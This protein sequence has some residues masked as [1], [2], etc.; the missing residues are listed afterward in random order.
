MNPHMYLLSYG[1][2]LRGK[3]TWLKITPPSLGVT[4]IQRLM[5]DQIKISTAC[6]KVGQL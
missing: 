1:T 4:C 3:V 6:L 5:K 2:V